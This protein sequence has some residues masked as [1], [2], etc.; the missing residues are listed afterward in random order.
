MKY[1][2]FILVAVFLVPTPTHA[3]E[4]ENRLP[5]SVWEVEMRLQ[6]IPVYDRAFN[7]YGEEAPLQQ[8]MLWDRVWRDSV[9]GKLQ[10]EEQR[11]E[12]RMAYGLT[13]KWMLEATIPLLQKK[14]TSTLKIESAST[15]QQKV[16]E[17]L[18]SENLS[19]LGDIRLIFAKDMV[20]TTSWHNRGGFTLRLPTGTT[21]TCL[22][23]TSPSPRDGLLS[24]MPSSA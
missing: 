16:L 21:G 4:L 2:L 20:A 22:L 9:V 19:G 6:N 1:Y 12:I 10:R 24:S 18:A 3:I 11:L 17:N 5:E 13:E 23:Y 7:G 15:N 14:Q 8:L